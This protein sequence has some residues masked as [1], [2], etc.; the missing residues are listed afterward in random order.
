MPLD[1]GPD[2]IRDQDQREV[3]EQIQGV[4]LVEANQ[5]P[6]IAH[7]DADRIANPCHAG[8]TQGPR[9]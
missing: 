4:Q 3:M 5:R 8:P 2:G 6:G 9:V 1:L 7:D